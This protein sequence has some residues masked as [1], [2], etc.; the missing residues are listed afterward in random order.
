MA[1]AFLT[2]T[3]VTR[4]ALRVL[5]QKLNF[6]GSITRDYDDSFARQGA[7]IGDTLKIRLPNQY[8]VRSGSNLSATDVTES[9]VSLQV[10]T[11]KGVDLNFSSVDLTLALDDFSERIIEPAMAVLAANIEADAMTMYKDVFN[12]VDNQGQ[13]ASFAKVLQ[14]RKILV[15]NLAPLNGRTCNLNT[16]D[17][18]DMVT[19]LKGLFNDQDTIGKQ[20]REGYM[21]R[22]A[23][24]D[25]M[26][27]TLWPSHPRGAATSAYTTSTLTGVLP[28]SATPVTSITVATG[29]GA[30]AHGDIFTIAGVFRVHP[31]TKQSTG[32]LQQ[33][34]VAADYAGG[35]GAI[36]ITPSIILSGPTQNVVIPTPS[37]TA[38]LSFSG[39]ISTNYGLSMAYQKGAFAFATADMVMPRG[40]DFAARETF[41]GVSMRI[42]RQYDI[43]ADKFPCRLDV[44]YGYKTIRP[45][46]ACRLANH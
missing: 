20:N 35:A 46:L 3:A 37:A 24:F 38:S 22:T 44:L 10:Q 13:A 23:G 15:D 11:Q 30:A 34:A 29:T 5:H 14:G 32:I 9:S 43:N 26:E 25:F 8:T 17:N 42:V 45:Q 27:N 12:Q 2:P 1:N 41:D 28:V 18:V 39:V 21:G 19:D 36:S 40:V 7:K 4:E 16:Q 6:V 33:F 31:E